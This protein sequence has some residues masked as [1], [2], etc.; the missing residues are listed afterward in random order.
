MSEQTFSYNGATITVH[1]QTGR[2]YLDAQIVQVRLGAI[3]MQDV[4]QRIYV[5]RF[6]EAYSQSTVEGEL[7]FEWPESPVDEVQLQIAFEGWLNLPGSV[8]EQWLNTLELVNTPPNDPDLL[9]P[10][11]VSEAKKKTPK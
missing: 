9:P 7:G 2:D 11:Q 4:R 5:N 10:E 3:T 6:S 8:M 1:T